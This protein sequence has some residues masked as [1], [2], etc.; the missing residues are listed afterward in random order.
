M[1]GVLSFFNLKVT[2]SVNFIKNKLLIISIDTWFDKANNGATELMF[3]IS[4]Y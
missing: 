2:N 3:D 1:S 4:S